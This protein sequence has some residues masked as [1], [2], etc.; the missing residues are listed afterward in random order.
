[1]FKKIIHKSDLVNNNYYLLKF[2]NENYERSFEVG[3]W[4]SGHFTVSFGYDSED[5][6]FEKLSDIW[7]LND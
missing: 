2:K 3:L 1:M 6:I 7:T 5:Y 4:Q